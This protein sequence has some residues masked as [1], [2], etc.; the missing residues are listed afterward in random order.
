MDRKLK[1]IVKKYSFRE[2][3]EL[4]KGDLVFHPFIKGEKP[5][6]A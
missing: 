6:K 2:N 5:V 3:E 4:K 1:S